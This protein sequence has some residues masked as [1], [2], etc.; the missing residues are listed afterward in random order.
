MNPRIEILSPKKVIGKRLTMS[1]T[2]NKTFQLW[3][4]FMPRRNEIL[5]TVTPNLYA[6]QVYPSTYFE[7]FNPKTLFEKWAT[8]EV[9][10][11]DTLPA[12]MESFTLPGGLYAVFEHKGQGTE[13]F[14]SIFK[15]WIPNSKYQID[16]RPHFEVLGEKYKRGEPT[17]EEEIWIPIQEKKL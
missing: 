5:K 10:T 16:H 8:L 6:I 1:L 11:F 7:A 12:T 13:L 17:S 3:Q 4:D 15:N 2:H 9:S 14:E